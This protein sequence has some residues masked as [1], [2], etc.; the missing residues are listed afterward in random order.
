MAVKVMITRLCRE[1]KTLELL[2][3]LNQLRGTAVS[4]M[5]YISGET[6]VSVDDGRRVVVL[7]T[8]DDIGH[9]EKWKNDPVRGKYEEKMEKFLAEPT[10]Y[11]VFAL[12]SLPK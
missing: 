6:L 2:N 9:W 12:G 5:G 8:W 10:R 4:Q 7:A 11:E 1:G 3:E